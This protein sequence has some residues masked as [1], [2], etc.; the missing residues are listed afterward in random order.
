MLLRLKHQFAAIVY[1]M[2]ITATASYGFDN[3]H[4]LITGNAIARPET[5]ERVVRMA[6]ANVMKG[7][8]SGVELSLQTQSIE[9]TIAVPAPEGELKE[10]LNIL[11]IKNSMN[12]ELNPIKTRFV[13]PQSALK[14]DIKKIQPNR[15]QVKAKWSIT[16]LS[17][18][19]DR[20]SI[21]VPKGV[22][23]AA[24]DIT[25]S[26]LKIGLARNSRPITVELDLLT[27]LT[28]NGTKIHL[29]S[30]KTNINSAPRPDFFITLGK[31]TVAGKPL[32]IEIMSNGKK[33]HAD[34]AAIRAQFQLLEPGIIDTVRQK[35]KDVIQE[36][37]SKIADQ[38][39]SEAPIKFSFES[40]QLLGTLKPETL[41]KL[42]WLPQMVGDMSG[43]LILSYLQ[44]VDRYKLFTGQAAS[45]VCFNRGTIDCLWEMNPT[46]NISTDDLKAVGP[47]DEI[48]ILLY[49]SWLQNLIHSDLFQKRIENLYNETRNPGVKLG[50][51]GVRVHLNPTKN[52]VVIVMNLEIDIKKTTKSDASLGKKFKDRFGDFWENLF[53]SGRAVQLPLEIAIRIKGI[54]K[55][56]NGK[57][58]LVL[59]PELPFKNG[60]VINTYGYPSNVSS[61]TKLVR[62]AF[63]SSVRDQIAETLN[64]PIRIPFEK[65]ID[66]NG[67][68][69]LPKNI[70][71]TPNHGILITAA[72]K[73]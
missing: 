15:F 34:E 14:I 50:K 11:G 70:S 23:D 8:F 65:I 17:A 35:L 61:M 24:F 38:I 21:R 10:I 32:E 47:A 25:S 48:G 33:L 36:Q 57:P 42:P 55:N 43:E 9:Q 51:S 20:L 28:P 73:N 26:P 52:A 45:T 18:T 22:F 68:K 30:L 13:L 29:V 6:V 59:I 62:D 31:L 69:F 19:S 58:E 5:I 39:E 7:Q 67:F 40:N 44:Y 60:T 49:E 56:A 27:D 3:E 1:L 2:L 71:I 41:K 37:F 63:L 4:S 66:I 46:S 54:E 16:R 53:G 12:I 64:G 72:M